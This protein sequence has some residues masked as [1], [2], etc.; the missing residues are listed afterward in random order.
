[1]KNKHD[2]YKCIVTVGKHHRS[3]NT[4]WMT[5]AVGGLNRVVELV[6]RCANKKTALPIYVESNATL[7][8]RRFSE[9]PEQRRHRLRV[10]R[11]PFVPPPAVCEAQIKRWRRGVRSAA[12]QRVDSA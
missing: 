8:H 7:I 5:C 6:I 9:V 12:S 3:V 4:V 2:L 1:M 10:L 11:L